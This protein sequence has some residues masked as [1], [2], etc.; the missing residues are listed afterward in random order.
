M[1][2][3]TRIE[4]E[5][6]GGR[7]QPRAPAEETREDVLG[8]RHL[9]AHAD[10]VQ[11]GQLDVIAGVAA[12][13]VAAA[14]RL[15]RDALLLALRV[16]LAADARA[17]QEEHGAHARRVEAVEQQRRRAAI[18]AVV[19]REQDDAVRRRARDDE[20]VAVRAREAVVHRLRRARSPRGW[21]QLDG[22]DVLGGARGRERA[23]R[24]RGR[25]ET[26]AVLLREEPS[27]G[28]ACDERDGRGQ[29]RSSDSHAA[30]VGGEGGG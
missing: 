20:P 14:E 28:S 8:L 24:E 29:E 5:P 19:E 16:V 21:K 15:L 26:V 13:D 2:P 12:D 18:G 11:R 9:R 30:I 6:P 17:R 23:R 1:S 22:D 3:S 10:V 25:L 7:M 4:R 27:C